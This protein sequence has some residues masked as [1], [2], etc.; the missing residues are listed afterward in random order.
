MFKRIIAI[1]T[2]LL[3]VGIIGSIF[4]YKSVSKAEASIEEKIIQDE[5][6]EI[7]IRVDEAS[8]EVLPTED[9]TAKIELTKK[10]SNYQL[11]ADVEGSMLKV[12]VESK[13]KKLFNFGF[14]SPFLS[15]K[16]FVPE[17]DY[18]SLDVKSDNGHLQINALLVKDV[19]AETDNGRI[20]LSNMQSDKV[21]ATANNGK[22][23]LE[24]VTAQLVNTKTNNGKIKLADV[25]GQLVG[26][27][28]NGSI[29][30]IAQEIDRP[31]DFATDNGK[32]LI[33]TEHEPTN[34][35]LD[36]K[37]DNGKVDYF[38]ES[39]WDTVIGDG[40]HVINLETKNGKITLK[41]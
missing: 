11:L 38:G 2:L 34:A 3:V 26:R 23:D 25:D 13:Q 8:V 17:K 41:H 22:I 36:I 24:N 20:K 9:S 21:I 5:F 18:V 35:I 37:I 39:T 32:I 27:T 12:V 6:D 19:E 4:T 28:N 31:I 40:E 15:L 29:S 30:L 7:D 1:A 16:V 10:Q 14:T 33:Q